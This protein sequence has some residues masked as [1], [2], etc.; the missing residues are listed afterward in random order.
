M[1]LSLEAQREPI[2]V[3]IEDLHWVDPES[4]A[5]ITRIVASISHQP[6]L[7]LATYRPEYR[8]DWLQRGSFLQVGLDQLEPGNVDAFLRSLIGR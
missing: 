4:E 1:L 5:A 8:H 6:I 7:L 2:V 3:L